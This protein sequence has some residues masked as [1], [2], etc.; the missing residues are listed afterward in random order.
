[1]V[2]HEENGL[3]DEESDGGFNFNAMD[4][5]GGNTEDVRFDFGIPLN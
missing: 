4:T 1:M 2:D 5:G 3:S